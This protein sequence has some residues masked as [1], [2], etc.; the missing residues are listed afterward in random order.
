MRYSN[1][2]KNATGY[3]AA[4]QAADTTTQD[5][6]TAI[7][8]WFELYYLDKATEQS[9]PCQQIP[10]TIVR[11][12]TKTVLSEHETKTED[13]FAAAVLKALAVKRVEALQMTLIGGEAFLKPVPNQ[14][15]GSFSFIVVPRNNLLVFARDPHGTVTDVGTVEV[16][17]AGNRYYT[18]LERRSMDAKGYLTIRYRLFCSYSEK[19]LGQA[20]P[21]GALPQYAQLQET[22]TFPR[23]IHSVGMVSVRTPMVNS[24]DGS[25]DAVSVYAPAMGLIRDI[26]ENE[27]QLNGE[28]RR[29]QSKVFASE[30]L[31]S[32]NAEGKKGIYSDLFVG[33]DEDPEAAGITIFSPTLRE[34]SYLARKQEYLRNVE[35]VIGLK[36]GLLSEV[37][38]AERTATEIT[39]SAG[40]YNLT[41]LDFQRMWEDAVRAVLQLCASL[42]QMYKLKDAHD[43]PEDAVTFSWGNGVLYDEAKTY[44]ELKE[45]VSMGLLQPERLVGWYH[46]LP[47]ETEEERKHIRENYM[48]AGEGE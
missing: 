6:R 3:A 11:K 40:E 44:A 14:Q 38:A 47:C 41:I 27:A 1:L 32:K 21:L 12:L 25:A 4:F 30:D 7:A 43:I 37:E 20:V 15:T 35:N 34:Q 24:V 22:Y 29:G 33:L 39:S 19:S 48:P 16:T 18:L 8:Q 17:A 42:G 2:L 46:N 36:R 9:D 26:N 23:P 31:I 45:Q 13:S 5:M 28:F 10:Q